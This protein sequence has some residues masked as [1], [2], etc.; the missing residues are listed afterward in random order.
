MEVKTSAPITP[1]VPP[2]GE[3]KPAVPDAAAAERL[4]REGEI[5]KRGAELKAE[6]DA[7]NTQRAQVLAEQK[8]LDAARAEIAE[9][10]RREALALTDPDGF[11]APIYGKDWTDK[12]ARAK[13][14]D[15]TS[16]DVQ[17]LRKEWEDER[18]AQAVAKKAEDEAKEKQKAE[19]TKTAA[20]EEE[21]AFQ[22][23]RQDIAG[24][25][26]KE[27]EKDFPSLART[28]LAREVA[29]R[30]RAH[31]QK[32]GEMPD[33]MEIAKGLE[34]ELDKLLESVFEGDPR[35]QEKV[36]AKIQPLARK[37]NVPQYFTPPRTPGARRS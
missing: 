6:K 8:K 36:K 16:L 1:A 25:W 10:K 18:A 11:L 12:L 26:M 28:G 37:S 24:R 13:A 15:A 35:W 23:Y 5:K 20:E 3:Q 7:L 9:A 22:E 33:E 4:K 27:H 29:N 21:R 17:K 32:T 14:G 34:S 2:N 19:E 31:H 30:V